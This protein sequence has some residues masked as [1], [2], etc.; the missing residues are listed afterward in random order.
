MSRITNLSGWIS[1]CKVPEPYHVL[2][3]YRQW[4]SKV[5]Y[6]LYSSIQNCIMSKLGKKKLREN[7]AQAEMF[8]QE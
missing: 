8:N 3:T 6:V 1:I 5:Y 2:L 7:L 4:S